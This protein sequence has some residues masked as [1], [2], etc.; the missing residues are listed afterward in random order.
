MTIY[1][2]DPSNGT[3]YTAR[4]YG[5]T[6][7]ASDGREMLVVDKMELIPP[8]KGVLLEIVEEE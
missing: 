3:D 7:T 1:A 4:V 6:E 8:E 5:H 2:C